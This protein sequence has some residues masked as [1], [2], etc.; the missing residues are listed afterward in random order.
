MTATA[1]ESTFQQDII[2][3]LVEGVT[4]HLNRRVALNVVDNR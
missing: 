1:A 3:E 4:Q 2:R